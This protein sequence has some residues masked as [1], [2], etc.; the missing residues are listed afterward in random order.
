MIFHRSHL[1]CFHWLR[2]WHK[3]DK[4]TYNTQ[5]SWH[6]IIV[7]VTMSKLVTGSQYEDLIIQQT[8][9]SS[10]PSAAYMHQWIESALV[11]IMACRLLGAKPLSN[12]CLV[13]VNYTLRS[14]LQWNFNPNSNFFIQ[15][16]A[17]QNVVWQIGSHF[18]HGGDELSFVHPH[19]TPM[20]T[21]WYCYG[22]STEPSN[23]YIMWCASKINEHRHTH[24][25]LSL[26]R[27]TE[28][29]KFYILTSMNAIRKHSC[30]IVWNTHDTWF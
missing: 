15:E 22:I 21:T 9:N 6:G 13:I 3:N 16:N 27:E 28:I 23:E 19:T 25:I 7:M 2:G 18:V 4:I 5:S 14:K 26:L 29:W 24:L 20:M 10:L 17:F 8:L 11:Q 1:K 12:Q 30:E